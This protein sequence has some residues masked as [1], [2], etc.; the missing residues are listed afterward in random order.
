MFAKA[1][2][3]AYLCMWFR[4]R[5][6]LQSPPKNVSKMKD[7]I[8][9][10]MKTLG[11]TQ[12]EFAAKLCVAEGTLSSIFN[13]RTKPTSNMVTAIHTFFPE[14]SVNWLMFGEGEMYTSASHEEH[15]TQAQEGEQPSLSFPEHPTEHPIAVPPILEEI[16]DG[17]KNLN[18]PQR[19]PV[20]IRVFFDDGTFEI[21]APR[22]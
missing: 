18:K 22:Q 11:L 19:K 10:L 3:F 12:K 8:Y 17:V 14:V 15:D 7:R 16:R 6:G 20:E 13:G 4:N 2:Y 1:N 21:F 9:Q 5:K